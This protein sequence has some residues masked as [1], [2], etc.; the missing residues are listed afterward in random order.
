VT[1][2]IVARDAVTGDMGVA[3][4][5]HWFSVGTVVSWG[6]AGFGVVAT[7]A[8]AEPAYGPR[9][10]ALMR[11]GVS[12]TAAL[13]ALVA[14]DPGR[15]R[16]QVAMLDVTGTVVA[17]TG[18]QCI[19]DAGDAQADGVSVQA[20]MMRN[21]DVWPAMLDAFQRA[22][23]ALDER[24]LVAL[25][26]AEAAGGDIRG[27]QSAAMLIVRGSSSGQS[28][29]DRT[30]DLRVDDSPDPIAELRRLVDVHRAYRHMEVAESREFEGDMEGA[31]TEYQ[32]A[33][34]LLRG[35]DE[36]AFWSAVMLADIGRG[37]EARGLFEEI[38]GRE[39]GW[40][41][42]L[43]RLPAAGLL[44]NGEKTVKRLLE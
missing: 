43:R 31:L 44:R 5:S 29:Q 9:G 13:T 34:A 19:A 16:R 32:Q 17:H 37:A 11:A 18:E 8:N 36:A 30:V 12:A 33:R 3:V 26:A 25:E 14:A 21:T 41:E 22:R 1:Y 24:L 15:E 27:R 10:L 40:A 39:P 42:L 35:N 38:V 4:Q 23:G 2:S 20:N 28:W 7:Q 6:E